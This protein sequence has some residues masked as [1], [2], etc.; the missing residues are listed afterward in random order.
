MHELEMLT[1][2]ALS[3][4]LERVAPAAVVPFGSIEHHGG[5]LPIGADALLADALGREGARERGAVL[6]PTGR[7]CAAE[8]HRRAPGT[9][10]L[11]AGTLADVAAELAEDLARQGF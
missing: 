6:A 11:R 2:H 7:V 1:G 10:A 3:G 4:L 5:H 8:P 9:L